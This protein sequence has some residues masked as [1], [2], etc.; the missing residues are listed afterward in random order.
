MAPDFLRE[1]QPRVVI[2][3]NPLYCDELRGA[4]RGLDVNADLL[5]V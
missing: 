5:T 3:M 1:Y 4:L 2:A